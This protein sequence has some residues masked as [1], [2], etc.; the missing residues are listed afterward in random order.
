MSVPV[1]V[2][3]SSAVIGDAGL[4]VRPDARGIVIGRPRDEARA[5]GLGDAL[6]QVLLGPELGGL[7]IDG[8]TGIHA[9]PFRPGRRVLL[10]HELSLPARVAPAPARRT[11]GG[12][13]ARLRDWRGRGPAESLAA[14]KTPEGTQDH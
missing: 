5:E 6:Q 11:A 3:K 1:H 4:D 8:S 14:T 7:G 2:R 9:E 10:G 12:S 13:P